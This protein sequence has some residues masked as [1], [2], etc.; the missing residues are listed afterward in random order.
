MFIP[1][2]LAN[3]ELVFIKF[4]RA[5]EADVVYRSVIANAWDDITFK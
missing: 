2:L 3:L 1:G 4:G 5:E